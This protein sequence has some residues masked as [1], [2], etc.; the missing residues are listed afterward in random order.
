ME[1]ISISGT[2]LEGLLDEDPD[3]DLN[4]GVD[5]L[6]RFFNIT[7]GVYTPKYLDFKNLYS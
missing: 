1:T 6:T 4:L 2:S 7:E 3:P 5:R